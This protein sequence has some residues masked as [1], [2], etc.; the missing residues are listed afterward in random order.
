MYCYQ[1]EKKFKHKETLKVLAMFAVAGLIALVIVSFE[2]RTVFI[3]NGDNEPVWSPCELKDV[4]CGVEVTVTK[5]TS[6]DEI[7][8]VIKAMF[9][10]NWRL[11][12]AVM[13]SESGGNSQAV[14]HN[15]NGSVDYGLW[16]INT[17]HGL[18]KKCMTDVEC[19]TE[20]AF[21]LSK[22]GTDWTPWVGFISGGYKKFL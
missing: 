15:N 22:G 12:K 2:D 10:D 7:D 5:V 18:D 11:A 4:V 21:K 16:Q 13:M 6:R 20:F 3:D 14:N 1:G 8:N 19:S 9:G 17:I